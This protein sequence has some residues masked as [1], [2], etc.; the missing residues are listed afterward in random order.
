MALSDIAALS[1]IGREEQLAQI[2]MRLE[3]VFAHLPDESP[4]RMDLQVAWEQVH[5]FQ[6]TIVQL[7]KH[8]RQANALIEGARATAQEAVNQRDVIADDLA[9]LVLALEDLNLR[10][11]TVQRV[12]ERIAQQQQKMLWKS[13]ANKLGWIHE[14][15]GNEGTEDAHRLYIALTLDMTSDEPTE[16]GLDAHELNMWRDHLWDSVRDLYKLGTD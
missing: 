7:E 1:K 13:L 5:Q 6:Q 15:D 2:R 8:L 14:D 10:N 11:Q 16:H 3:Q 4:A 12:Y 9:E